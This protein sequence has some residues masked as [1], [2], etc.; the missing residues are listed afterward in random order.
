MKDAKGHGSDSKGGGLLAA[1]QA[2]IHELGRGPLNASKEFSSKVD[3]AAS[4]VG[5]KIKEFLKDETGAVDESG[6]LG[7]TGLAA[8]TELAHEHGVE[9]AHIFQGMGARYGAG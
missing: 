3:A 7:A 1:H 9:I 2:M 8:L 4:K 6:A 5:G